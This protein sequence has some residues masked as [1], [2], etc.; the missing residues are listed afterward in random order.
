MTPQDGPRTTRVGS[1]GIQDEPR[2]VP[3]APKTAPGAAQ[4]TPEGPRTTPGPPRTRAH[5]R[6]AWGGGVP[7]RVQ[8]PPP[9]AGGT[10]AWWQGV[11]NHMHFYNSTSY[12][13]VTAR[14]KMPPTGARDTAPPRTPQTIPDRLLL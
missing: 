3:G 4:T 5:R 13:S 7:R 6:G 10:E 8:N 14:E 9:H 12:L 1:R 11:Q 2:S